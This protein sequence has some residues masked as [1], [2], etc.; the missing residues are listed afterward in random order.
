MAIKQR[1]LLERAQ[2]KNLVRVEHENVVHLVDAYRD[3][4]DLFLV[5]ESVKVS[6]WDMQKC[7]YGPWTEYELSAICQQT[8]DGLLYIRKQL[9]ASVAPDAS[10]ILVD[11]HGIVKIGKI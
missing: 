2:V 10:H 7:P 11:D 8:L 9:G 5:Y 4:S 3:S 1:L 6:L